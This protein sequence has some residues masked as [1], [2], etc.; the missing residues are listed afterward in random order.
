MNELLEQ[1]QKL[2]ALML[3]KLSAITNQNYIEAIEQA[4]LL[5][6]KAEHLVARAWR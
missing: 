5:I 2:D 4:R 1:M 6:I 3:S